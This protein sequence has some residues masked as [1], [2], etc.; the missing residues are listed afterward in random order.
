MRAGALRSVSET[1][2][3]V[4]NIGPH[5][6][7]STNFTSQLIGR[8]DKIVEHRLSFFN[9]KDHFL[10]NPIDWNKD[11][12]HGKSAPLTY[13]QSIDYRDFGVT[14][15]CKLVWEPNRHHHLVVFGR[16]YRAS[17]DIRYA[18]EVVAQLQSWMDQCPFAKG[19]NWRSP[20][21]LGIRLI[22]WVWAIE[23]IRESRLVDG[24]FRKRFLHNV[25][26]HLWEVS[27]KFSKGSSANNHLVGEAAGVYIGS[28]YFSNFQK[29]RQMAG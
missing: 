22:N 23:L 21:E 8:A 27:R 6:R 17:G 10:G 2:N 26:L 11:H 5:G 19:M 15:D 12:G 24:E 3:G 13:S 7:A 29:R 4:L 14:G 25:Y 20:L 28:S 1:K 9:L 18:A 16:A